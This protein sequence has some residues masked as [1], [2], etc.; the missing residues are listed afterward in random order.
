MA[1]VET[2]ERLSKLFVL[3]CKLVV[4]DVFQ[5]DGLGEPS[6]E[7]L[8]IIYEKSVEVFNVAFG[9]AEAQMDAEMCE[10]MALASDDVL[11][12]MF[13]RGVR[14][15]ILEALADVRLS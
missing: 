10:A 12:A 4:R 13:V 6:A 2:R 9:P 15:K 3:A 1:P 14:P 11:F 7:I 5:T 8:K